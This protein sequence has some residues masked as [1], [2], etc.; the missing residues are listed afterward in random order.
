M[1][2]YELEV[3]MVVSFLG[4]WFSHMW[5]VVAKRGE[6]AMAESMPCDPP[7]PNCTEYPGPN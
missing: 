5:L 4:G 3:L 2:P 6:R 7:K 1:R